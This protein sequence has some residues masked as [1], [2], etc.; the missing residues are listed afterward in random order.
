MSL[1]NAVSHKGTC[2]INIFADR[3]YFS[4]RNLHT[5]SKHFKCFSIYLSFFKMGRMAVFTHYVIYHSTNIIILGSCQKNYMTEKEEQDKRYPYPLNF[6]R[7]EMP[8]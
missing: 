3:N 2:V 5:A 7:V 6:I 4:D 8:P 1:Q